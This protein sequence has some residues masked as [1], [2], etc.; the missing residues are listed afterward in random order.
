MSEEIAT[1]TATEAP[2]AAETSANV[3]ASSQAASQAAANPAAPGAA[4][5]TV[6]PS[7]YTPNYKFKV[8]DQEKEFDEWAKKAITD[9]QM[10]KQV[11]QLYEKAHGLDFVKNDRTR[12]RSELEKV[13]QEHTGLRKS[14][15]TL[16]GFVQKGD[17]LS[18]FEALKIP[19]QQVFKWVHDRI[20]F[21]QKPAQEQ[22]V[23]NQA[24]ME[25]QRVQTLMEQNQQLQTMAQQYA[26]NMR[27]QE[28]DS[29][30]TRP[31]LADFANRYDS[32]LGN[33][34]A[35]RRAVVERGQY[36][37][38]TTGKD[39]PVTQAI[40]EVLQILG[41]I[42][43]KTAAAPAQAAQPA[44]QAQPEGTPQPQAPAVAEKKPVITNVQGRG[45]ASPVRKV[46]KTL[47]DLKKLADEAAA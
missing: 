46:P 21:L 23:Y 24:R 7:P 13:S 11:R 43:P 33:P 47:A 27:M 44:A 16:S 10:E 15:D 8:L 12:L 42:P 26:V 41:A 20:Q 34:G 31:E 19:E 3:E 38:L 4:Q 45:G 32:H 2:A 37:A 35:F 30:L 1:Q 22:Q 5:T 25:S 14:I 40:N 6:Q 39:I 17:F 9:A 36:H 28:M 29:Y 18:F